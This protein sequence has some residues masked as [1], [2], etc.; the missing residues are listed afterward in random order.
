[1]LAIKQF[2]PPIYEWFPLHRLTEAMELADVDE[3][4]HFVGLC[5]LCIKDS[6]DV[7]NNDNAINAIKKGVKK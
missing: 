6:R 7:A 4:G 2:S 3:K 5:P 1:V